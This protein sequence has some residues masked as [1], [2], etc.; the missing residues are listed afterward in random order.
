MGFFVQDSWKFS[1]RLTLELGLRYDWNQTP[2]EALDRFAN[3]VITNGQANLVRTSSPYNQNNMNFQPR[4]GFALDVF[5]TGR[6]IVRSGYA[7]LTDQPITNLV[8]GL[9]GNQPF[10]NPLAFN[11]GA[12]NPLSLR[13]IPPSWGCGRWRFGSYGG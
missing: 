10:G 9:T 12:S 4:L 6:T 13:P 2:T 7:I 5:G 1:Q 8:T 3:L 11:G